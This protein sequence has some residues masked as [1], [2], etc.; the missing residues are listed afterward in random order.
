MKLLLTSTLLPVCTGLYAV[1][2]ETYSMRECRFMPAITD[3]CLPVVSRG[4]LLYKVGVHVAVSHFAVS[5]IAVSHFAGAHVD[6]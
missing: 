3:R 4:A 6:K 2:N 5:H 1:P